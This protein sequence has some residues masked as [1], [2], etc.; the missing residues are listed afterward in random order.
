MI[1]QTVLEKGTQTDTN[2]KN[3]RIGRQT[4]VR[5]T[6]KQVI[7]AAR[8]HWLP[9]K[10]SACRS[11]REG[12]D[13]RVSVTRLFTD[14]HHEHPRR[15]VDGSGR[16]QFRFPVPI[17]SHTAL[18]TSR[19]YRDLSL[20]IDLRSNIYIYISRAVGKDLQKPEVLLCVAA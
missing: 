11:F 12:Q 3:N 7:A 15:A 13:S 10:A 16:Q 5:T 20:C 9:R 14:I 4:T 6:R 8:G 19:R 18:R 1:G 2:F 17:P